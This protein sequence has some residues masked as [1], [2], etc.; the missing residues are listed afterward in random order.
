MKKLINLSISCLACILVMS[1]CNGNVAKSPKV[2]AKVDGSVLVID[3]DST[4][5]HNVNISVGQLASFSTSIRGG[6]EFN[7]MDSLKLKKSSHYEL[8][9]TLAQNGGLMDAHIS[10]PSKLDT[11]LQCQF[12]YREI[13][14]HKG[15]I[16]SGKFAKIVNTFDSEHIDSDL[17]RWVYKNKKVNIG[18]TLFNAMRLYL[19]ELNISTNTEF[20]VSGDIPAMKSSNL[21][22]NTYKVSSDMQADHYFLFAGDSDEDI[23]FFIEEMIAN[24]MAYAQKDLSNLLHCYI[25]NGEWGAQ[26][27]FL[28]GI[29]DNWTTQVVPLGVISIDDVAPEYGMLAKLYDESY[30]KYNFDKRG[31]SVNVSPHPQVSGKWSA[32][33]G[34]FQGW[35]PHNVPWTFTWSGDVSKIVVH[36][37][38]SLTETISLKGKTSPYHITISTYLPNTGDNYVKLEAYDSLGNKSETDINIALERVKDDT[39]H[40]DIDNNIWN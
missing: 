8:A 40:I 9:Y 17:R 1:G 14:E 39:P 38:K 24:N 18:D 25:R 3:A 33:F 20:T 32:S 2:A 6:E 26:C 11:T 37:S 13:L 22:G 23:D 27:I 15:E 19:R 4:Q 29:N 30:S 31:F 10:I 12:K 16:T 35:S 34:S 28:I 5:T 36:R 7:L 21:K